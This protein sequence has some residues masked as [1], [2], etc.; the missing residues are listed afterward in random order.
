MLDE[1][2]E[3]ET[4]ELESCRKDEASHYHFLPINRGVYLMAIFFYCER[5]KH[6]RAIREHLHHVG[7]MDRR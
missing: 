4:R 2:G 6:E 7:A 1:R 5:M 3:G